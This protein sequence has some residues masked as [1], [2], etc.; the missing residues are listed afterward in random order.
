MR[1]GAERIHWL[2]VHSPC[3]TLVDVKQSEAFYEHLVS[4]TAAKHSLHGDTIQKDY[5]TITS[6]HNDMLKT[7]Q[8]SDLIGVFINSLHFH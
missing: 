6:E 4:L 5:T 7:H 8:Y 2:I 1:P 3:D